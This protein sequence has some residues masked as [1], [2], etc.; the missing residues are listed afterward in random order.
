[1]KFGE[2]GTLTKE[3]R[4]DPLSPC[5][6]VLSRRTIA[7][8]G[9]SSLPVRILIVA[10]DTLGEL[11]MST[12]PHGTRASSL[13]NAPSANVILYFRIKVPGA[14]NVIT[15]HLLSSGEMSVPQKIANSFPCH[16][17]SPARHIFTTLQYAPSVSY[18]P[19]EYSTWL[20]I[21][22]RRPPRKIN[23]ETRV[24][25]SITTKR[26]PSSQPI[27]LSETEMSVLEQ[28]LPHLGPMNRWMMW[29]TRIAIEVPCA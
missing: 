11:D 14:R 6:C 27:S 21:N 24:K 28:F 17:A 16:L 8:T 10:V 3:E 1:M 2:K 20:I 7:T 5:C 23:K 12:W 15:Q 19:C 9:T 13:H 26:R 18:Q 4:R 25:G 29:V 22:M